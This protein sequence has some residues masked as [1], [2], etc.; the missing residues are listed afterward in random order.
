MQGCNTPF[1][2]VNKERGLYEL[3]VFSLHLLSH[4]LLQETD[5]PT[6]VNGGPV[7]AS[8]PRGV[9]SRQR[10]DPDGRS[11]ADT[12]ADPKPECRS[13]TRLFRR[14]PSPLRAS[15]SK[16]AVYRRA[17][18]S[19]MSCRVSRPPLLQP[20]LGTYFRTDGFP[21]GSLLSG[22]VVPFRHYRPG[23]PRH[24][25]AAGTRH[26]LPLHQN[27]IRWQLIKHIREL[28]PL[29]TAPASGG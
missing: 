22:H 7:S 9:L 26:P 1:L 23:F 29:H 2:S 24:R 16:S 20:L 15:R 4:F 17:S 21:G 25:P 27:R 5:R 10:G 12:R 18:R 14:L 19:R 8:Q 6:D 11:A 3:C 28:R 13:L